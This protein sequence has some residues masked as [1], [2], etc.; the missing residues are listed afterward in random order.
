MNKACD[1]IVKRRIC[2]NGFSEWWDEN[3]TDYDDEF[4]AW[5]NTLRWKGD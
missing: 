2:V 3:T 1:D 5:V 4:V